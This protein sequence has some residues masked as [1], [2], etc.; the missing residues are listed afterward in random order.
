MRIQESEY[1]IKTIAWLFWLLAPVFSC[2]V[3]PAPDMGVSWEKNL[4][5]HNFILY[6][7]EGNQR[8]R[9]EPENNT[10]PKSLFP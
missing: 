1:R 8:C 2:F 6:E 10:C 4:Y 7:A 5:F 3:V 9:K